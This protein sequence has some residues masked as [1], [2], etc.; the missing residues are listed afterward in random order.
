MLFACWIF[1]TGQPSV[2]VSIIIGLTVGFLQDWILYLCM[3]SLR[4]VAHTL[5]VHATL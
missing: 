4:P 5:H 3:N 2:P 1:R